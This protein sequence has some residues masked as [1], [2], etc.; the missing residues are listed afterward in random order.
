MSRGSL[1]SAKH[2]AP[3]S[4]LKA[5]LELRFERRRKHSHRPLGMLLLRVHLGAPPQ[6]ITVAGY[7][8][9]PLKPSTD[10]SGLG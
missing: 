4:E 9:V 8:P 1:P 10:K 2:P 6:D 5:D 7:C 3:G